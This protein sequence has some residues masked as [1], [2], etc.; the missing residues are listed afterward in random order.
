MTPSSKT[1]I[2]VSLISHTNVG[3]TSLARTLLRKDIGEIR[4]QP[5][6]TVKSEAYLLADSIDAS[7]FLWD[8]PG[9]GD[10][11]KILQRIQKEGGATGWIL[12][13]LVDRFRDRSLFCSLEAL[14]NIKSSTDLVFYL[15]NAF[16]NPDVAGYPAL[17]MELLAHF[18]KN[19]VVVVNQLNPFSKN[20]SNQLLT[21]EWQQFMKAYPFV[22]DVLVMDAFQ[23]LPDH[24]KSLLLSIAQFVSKEKAEACRVL[25]QSFL[26][27]QHQA[28]LECRKA[29]W[30]VFHFALNQKQRFSGEES[31]DLEQMRKDLAVNMS[32]YSEALMNSCRISIAD[33]AAIKAELKNIR[34]RVHTIPE[35]T[36]GVWG[37]IVSGALSGLSADLIAGGLSFGG[38]ALIGG[39]SG[40]LA[41]YFGTRSLNQLFRKS[42][43][44]LTWS[45]DFLA[46]LFVTLAA[47]YQRVLHHGRARGVVYFNDQRE[48]EYWLAQFQEPKAGLAPFL[49]E[50][51]N[52]SLQVDQLKAFEAR[53]DFFLKQVSHDEFESR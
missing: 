10:V 42:R 43:E 38:G 49:S 15:V 29:A 27:A 11:R 19:V 5:H 13:H 17:E 1:E 48:T 35:K 34:E 2:Y 8:T 26:D 47:L 3:K 41:A 12:H 30:Q 51:R 4:D 23:P 32:Q 33:Q 36:A 20:E 45:N 6:V 40:W 25:V 46:E 22:K 18:H 7:L 37:G 21:R 50:L 9:F 14:K 53:F 16:E 52:M 39:V 24:E 28:Y 44:H 31:K